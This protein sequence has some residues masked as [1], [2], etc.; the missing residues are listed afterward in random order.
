MQE[1]NQLFEKIYLIFTNSN[2]ERFNLF[3]CI[4]YFPFVIHIGRLKI[5]NYLTGT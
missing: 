5:F 4:Q 3:N 2:K 1:N